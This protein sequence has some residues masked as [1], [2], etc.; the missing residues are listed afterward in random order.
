[1]SYMGLLRAAV[2][3]KQQAYVRR[4]LAKRKVELLRPVR[5]QWSMDGLKGTTLNRKAPEFQ[6]ENTDGFSGIFSQRNALKW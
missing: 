4:R 6:W 2:S 1:M 3:E 5:V